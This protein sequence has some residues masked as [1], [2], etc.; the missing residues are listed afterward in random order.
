MSHCTRYL[1][2][3]SSSSCAISPS[4]RTAACTVSS[5]R[6]SWGW[7]A[8]SLVRHSGPGQRRA[9]LCN[10][11]H[12]VPVP[13]YQTGRHCAG[14]GCSKSKFLCVN[15]P[16]M[17]LTKEQFQYMALA[18]YSQKVHERWKAAEEKHATAAQNLSRERKHRKQLQDELSRA[19][20]QTIDD[21]AALAKSQAKVKKWEDRMPV[22][23]NLIAGIKPMTEFVSFSTYGRV[24]GRWLTTYRD[25]HQMQSKLRE[26]GY[27]L[28]RKTYGFGQDAREEAED[29]LN[30]GDDAVNENA[31]G[32]SLSINSSVQRQVVAVS[33]H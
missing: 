28:P 20:L 33:T 19:R 8:K 1:P 31:R 5:M 14:H 6:S 11:A 32:T 10:P 13:T 12:M 9:R 21:A 17:H 22:I 2:L 26:L 7:N 4:W 30:A 24:T 23:N 3:T 29:N 16:C 27:T 18:R 15:T 25:I